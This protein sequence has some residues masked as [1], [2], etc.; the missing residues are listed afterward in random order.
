MA[1]WVKEIAATSGIPSSLPGTHIVEGENR[2]LNA[3]H[4]TSSGYCGTCVCVCTHTSKQ[5]DV[6]KI[7][8]EIRVLAESQKMKMFY[9]VLWC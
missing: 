2:L 5:I 6:T 4:L 1:H 3:V 7:K 8:T 9:Y